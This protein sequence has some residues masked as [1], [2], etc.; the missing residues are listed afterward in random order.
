M[1]CFWNTKT[2]CSTPKAKTADCWHTNIF[3]LFIQNAVKKTELEIDLQLLPGAF[4]TLIYWLIWEMPDSSVVDTELL[5]K[6]C[7]R[8]CHHLHNR[9]KPSSQDYSGWK[10]IKLKKG[11]SE[12]NWHVSS[13][14][15]FQTVSVSW[16]CWIFEGFE[17]YL[18]GGN[19]WSWR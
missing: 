6:L 14:E 12:E 4:L 13:T 15:T 8:Q 17:I 19:E 16:T 9:T 11:F 5:N 3:L 10:L 7:H 18:H 2:S 1:E